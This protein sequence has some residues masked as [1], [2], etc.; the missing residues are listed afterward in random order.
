LNAGAGAP[1]V[2][3]AAA[4]RGGRTG[5][6]AAEYDADGDATQV[7]GGDPD[8]TSTGVRAGNEASATISTLPAGSAAGGRGGRGGGGGGFGGQQGPVTIAGLTADPNSSTRVVM[9]FRKD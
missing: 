9:Q 5:G 7:V 6:L 2:A 8:K 3:D 1:A 4:G